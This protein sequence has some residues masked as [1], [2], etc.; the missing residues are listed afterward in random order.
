MLIQRKR[1]MVNKNYFTL[2][3]FLYSET[4]L[5]NKIDNWPTDFWIIENIQTKI[6]PVL[7][8]LREA[9]CGGIRITSGY[10]SEALNKAVKGSKTSMHMKGLAVDM[11]PSNGDFK[12][13]VIFTVGFFDKRGFD[14]LIIETSGKS[15]W[16]HLG[17]ESN[18]GM[19]R[20]Q[21]LN[22]NL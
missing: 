4:A 2:H 14:Q 15:Q 21:I 11:V 22:I 17:I 9:W 18:D 16:L 7:N 10:R 1:K 12:N 8:Q 13:F 19:K 5:K 20:K 3:E 6:L